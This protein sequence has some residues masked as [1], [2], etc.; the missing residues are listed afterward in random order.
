M[1][2]PDWQSKL[3]AAASSAT[4]AATDMIEAARSSRTEYFGSSLDDPTESLADSLRLL[5]EARGRLRLEIEP[6]CGDVDNQLYGAL[7]K[8]LEER[9]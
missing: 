4:D 8:Y 7:V 9:G 5:I 2:H 6:R 3:L 1:T